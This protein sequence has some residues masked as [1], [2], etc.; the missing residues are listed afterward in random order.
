MMGRVRT[1]FP[2]VDAAPARTDGETEAGAEG[3]AAA[4][5]LPGATTPEPA[6]T[7]A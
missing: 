7:V 1:L 2:I 5:G 6:R 4:E 3:E